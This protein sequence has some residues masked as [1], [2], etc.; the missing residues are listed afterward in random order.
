MRYLFIK[1]LLIFFLMPYVTLA[2]SRLPEPVMLKTASI[3]DGSFVTWKTLAEIVHPFMQRL[4]ERV[5]GVTTP[6]GVQGLYH[7][8][9]GEYTLDALADYANQYAETD[10]IFLQLFQDIKVDLIALG[11]EFFGGAE[12]AKPVIAHLIKESCLARGNK[13]SLL[14]IWTRARVGQEMDLFHAHIKT[15]NHLRDF[16]IDLLTFLHDFVHSCPKAR[17]QLHVELE[18]WH[19]VKN[20]ISSMMEEKIILFEPNEKGEFLHYLK[21]HALPRTSLDCISSEWIH[22]HYT[23]FH[24]KRQ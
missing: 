7:Y 4:Y 5:F 12:K 20:L 18:K 17:K 9:N 23:V 19:K 2:I 11:N 1:S 14:I 3:V 8:K 24:A 10:P 13:D 21:Q 15:M 22:H 16:C 6:M